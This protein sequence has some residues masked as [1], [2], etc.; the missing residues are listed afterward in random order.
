MRTEPETPH[1]DILR[2]LMLEDAPRDADL[3]IREL[4]RAGIAGEFRVVCTRE[5]MLRELDAFAPDIILSDYAMPQ[6][7]GMEALEIRNEHAP[8]LPF[9]IVTGSINEETA[10]ECIKRGA[11]D[12]VTKTHLLGLPHAV[13]NALEKKRLERAERAGLEKIRLTAQQ[14]QTTLDAM[15]EAV[16]L[17][18]VDQKII[19]CNTAMCKLIGKPMDQVVGRPVYQMVQGI[20]QPPPACPA[21]RAGKTL[22]RETSR[23]MLGSRWFDFLADPILDVRRLTG[24][25]YIV[26]D[27][28]ERKQNEDELADHRYRLEELVSVRTTALEKARDEQ[29]RISEELQGK[30]EELEE[31]LELAGE[32]ELA[33]LPPMDTYFP[34]VPD[35][36]RNRLHLVHYYLPSETV[37]GDFYTVIPLSPSE[38]GIFV[39]DVT[40]HGIRAAL[41]MAILRGLLEHRTTLGTDPGEFL[42]ALNADFISVFGFAKQELFAT[43]AYLVVNVDTGAVRYSIAGHP[44]PLLVDRDLKRVTILQEDDAGH[45]P[46]L[47]LASDFRYQTLR[48][49]L[50]DRD[51]LVVIT[52]GL[53][54]AENEARD[55]YGSRRLEEA[56]RSRIQLSETDMLLGVM[57]EVQ[58]YVGH[59]RF[60]DDVCLVGVE[61]Q[62]TPKQGGE[63][64]D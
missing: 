57:N 4:R 2:I 45:G 53:I 43:A 54:E 42:T 33:L 63:K 46:A 56:L 22:K 1:S 36:A 6:F 18:T 14:W 23:F 41:V 21:V 16:A 48:T 12:Y 15:Q 13:R 32:V 24:I 5:D 7:T 11:D 17:L 40:G 28:T 60:A 25:V 34:A 38:A 51:L 8:G 62:R 29:I 26:A 47:G 31:N 19:R 20:D 50:K 37:G 30:N 59:S 61:F 27:I 52:D 58:E 9:V 3:E 55:L 64:S 35:E 10:V 39:C 44:H 49:G